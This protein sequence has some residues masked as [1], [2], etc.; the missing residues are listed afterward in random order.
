M[1]RNASKDG[2]IGTEL[3]Q[4]QS[5]V[6]L[7]TEQ[8]GDGNGPPPTK[9][10]KKERG[11]N[12]RRPR[13]ARVNHADQLCPSLNHGDR[14]N[15]FCQFGDK[16]R[17]CHD[18]SEFLAKKPPDIAESC[19][20]FTKLGRCPYGL[21]CRYG[22]SHMT[23]DHQNRINED[24]FDPDR[25][26]TTINIIS[27]S[28][29]E[30]LRKKKVELPK[31]E[32]FLKEFEREK[33]GIRNNQK[34][35]ELEEGGSGRKEEK[36]E[37]EGGKEVGEEG[38]G[39]M[40]KGGEDKEKGREGKGEGEGEMEEGGEDKERRREG[41]IGN[42][43]TDEV[44]EE[45]ANPEGREVDEVKEEPANPEG[46]EVDEAS[47]KREPSEAA[48]EPSQPVAGAVTDEDTVILRPEE[49]KKVNSK[50]YS[51]I[52]ARTLP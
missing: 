49:R 14:S 26:G 42:G 35:C 6:A 43:S 13:A 19:H 52:H 44:K 5:I 8:T 7:E 1:K 47:G 39:E 12:K 22:N 50:L 48:S 18:C 40:E 34:S 9:R 24:L 23:P 2:E 16:C 45:P 3:K 30:N 27:R 10:R 11:Q 28:L 4:E 21:A 37:G 38:K 46:R 41:T 17:Y 31:S 15:R 25:A 32:K 36:E 20:L 29:Q 51:Y 33:K